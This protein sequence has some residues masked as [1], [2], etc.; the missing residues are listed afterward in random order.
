MKRKKE[1]K[2]T[3]YGQTKEIKKKEKE[4]KKKRKKERKK[5]RKAERQTIAVEE[6]KNETNK[7]K[8]EKIY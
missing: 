6:G 5:E 2:T 8:N 7:R 3:D 4:Q 1:R